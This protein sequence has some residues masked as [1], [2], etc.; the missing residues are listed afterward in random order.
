MENI[1]WINGSYK[2]DNY[3]FETHRLAEMWADAL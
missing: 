3:I 1:I 2:E